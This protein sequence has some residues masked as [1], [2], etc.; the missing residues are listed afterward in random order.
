MLTHLAP[1]A[2]DCVCRLA[3]S[4]LCLFAVTTLHA[5]APLLD[6]VHTIATSDVS[7]PVEHDFDISIAGTYQVTLTD[8]GA[9]LTPPAP[10]AAVKLAITSN[11]ALVGIPL[12]GA[13]NLQF[14]AS[15][16]TY[17][18]HVVGT[19]GTV[20]GSGPIGIQVSAVSGGTVLYSFSDTI[21][22]PP[23]SSPSAVGLLDDSFT[24]TASGNYQVSI[25]DL[26]IPQSLSD[27]TLL[28]TAQGSATPLAILPDAS[29]G[30][31]LQAT[32][33][34]QTGVTYRIFA[35]GQ[36]GAAGSGTYSA[37]VA[38]QAG[39]TPAYS[40]TVAAGG[41]TLLGTTTL[42]AGN[43]NLVVGD[44][45]FPAAL[46]QVGV[47]VSSD[48][49]AAAS[50]SA[51]GTQSFSAAA[52][53]YQIFAVA[54]AGASGSGSYAV[55]IQ[56]QGGGTTA[57]SVARAVSA[58]G[59]ALSGYS[60]DTSIAAA[61]SYTVNLVDFQSPRP[62][63][64]G[65]LAAVQ[66]GALLGTPISAAGSFDINAVAGPLS[67]LVFAGGS[68]SGGSLLDV[69]VT[70]SSSRL[71]FDQPQGVGVAFAARP[72]AITAAGRYTVTTADLAFP[73]SFQDLAVI[74]TRGGTVIG[75]I[76]AGGT[77]PP[78]QAAAGNYFVNFL[79]T[80]SATDHTGTY[81]L[82]AAAAP[83]VPTVTLTANPTHVTTGGTVTLTWTSTNATS[84][85]G[86]GGSWTG[87]WTGAQAASGNTTSPPV[88][89]STTFTLTCDG[90]GGTAAQSVTVNVD[91]PSSGG[92]GV[93]DFELIALLS[94]LLLLRTRGAREP[95]HMRA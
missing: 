67:L 92:G 57:F 24:V 76:F 25:A 82:N 18:L 95:R 83:P 77:I 20:V 87:H 7:V 80:P 89:T 44:L 90:P 10:L 40:R 36:A 31:A 15:P 93:L 94:V 72:L 27:L 71:V 12:V 21:A 48:G 55:Q 91:P 5:Q 17:R 74:V 52:G 1:R 66:G 62:L 60:Y 29:N 46:T 49:Q 59:A 64:S 75:S 9:L 13:G 35:I 50:A 8:L 56:P 63:G 2:R 85:T 58:P 70:D 84:C 81:A 65:K 68:G 42:T 22:P 26:N 19:P 51:P 16:G 54:T 28:L 4:L 45:A 38:P 23:Q 11:D 34:L 88:S 33:A 32:V 73:S 3:G 14:T 61:G 30:N 43:Y 37:I 53:T 6:D 79:A 86:S 78:F 69:N 41:M 39:G 47:L